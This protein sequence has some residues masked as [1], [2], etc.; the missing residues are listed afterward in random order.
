MSSALANQIWWSILGTAICIA[1]GCAR[2][3][4]HF[5]WAM[6]QNEIRPF[7]SLFTSA[8]GGGVEVSSCPKQI[9]LTEED[10][11]GIIKALKEDTRGLRIDESYV[12]G[13]SYRVV[14]KIQLFRGPYALLLGM[15]QLGFGLGSYDTFRFANPSLS[16]ILEQLLRK[17]GVID[18]R[19]A[20][21]YH[22]MLVRGANGLVV[23]TLPWIGD[24]PSD[25]NIP[26]ATREKYDV[27]V[28]AISEFLRGAKDE[29]IGLR[30]LDPND[31]SALGVLV[32]DASKVLSALEEDSW[33]CKG[34]GASI[35]A[36]RQGDGPEMTLS[37][38]V[39]SCVVWIDESGFALGR[40]RQ[41]RFR[42]PRV[43]RELERAFQ[44]SGA[45]D[46]ADGPRYRRILAAGARK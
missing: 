25:G 3:K 35:V 26:G 8:E 27:A 34:S 2:P 31:D 46:S 4:A 10:K 22:R 45:F 17:N 23:P 36:S 18:Q 41:Y 14:L 19:L 37:L 33:P 21:W 43:S 28:R 7:F 11:N 5:T 13:T 6:G 1:G 16:C 42:N 39:L 15:D 30:I 9:P 44:E 12:R 24:S 38:G 32:D 29:E 20:D 40:N